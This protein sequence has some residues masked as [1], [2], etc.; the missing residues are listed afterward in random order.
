MTLPA[1]TH[2]LDEARA[3]AREFIEVMVCGEVF[4]LAMIGGS[5]RREKARVHDIEIICR[6][7]G[8]KLEMMIRGL[9]AQK[10]LAFRY[11]LKNGPRY[12]ALAFDGIPLDLFIVLPDRQWGP[13]VVIRTGP[14]DANKKLFAPAHKWGML[15]PGME[16]RDGA[17]HYGGAEL[18]TPEESDVFRALGLPY[19][20]PRDRSE[21]TYKRLQDL[22]NATWKL[23]YPD[24]E[25]RVQQGMFGSE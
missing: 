12:K 19:I 10:R 3:K 25:V 4:P 11:P 15:P 20:E 22:G 16:Q 7:H 14:A 17:L 13:M 5:I 9:G 8:Y 6:A 1:R 23:R 2:R 18:D 24:Q 21:A